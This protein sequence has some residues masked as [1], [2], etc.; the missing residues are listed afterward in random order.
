MSSKYKVWIE[1]GDIILETDDLA[2]A[3][4]EAA[5]YAVTDGAY[6]TDAQDRCI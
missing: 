1:S 3:I 2:A 4:A 6:I 5:K